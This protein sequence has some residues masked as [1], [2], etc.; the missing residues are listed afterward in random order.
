MTGLTAEYAIYGILTHPGALPAAGAAAWFTNAIEFLYPV[1]TFILMPLYFPTG[2]PVSRRWGLVAWLVLVLLPFVVFLDAFSPGEAE[3]GTG[4]QNPLVIEAM[5]PVARVLGPVLI[6][7]YLGM[8][9]A[10]ARAS[11]YASGAPR[12]W[13]ASR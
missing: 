12:A 9:F 4:I 2:R 3:T 1:L 6:A 13:S 11:S 10:S 7:L 5:N 8:I